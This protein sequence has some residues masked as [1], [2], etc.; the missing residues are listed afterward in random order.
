MVDISDIELKNSPRNIK[1]LQDE[2]NIA[3]VDPKNDLA[4]QAHPLGLCYPILLIN[5]LLNCDG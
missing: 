5:K 3:V 2:D 1:V 4:T